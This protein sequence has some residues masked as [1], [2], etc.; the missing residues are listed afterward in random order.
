[1]YYICP[2]VTKNYVGMTDI[3]QVYLEVS[4]VRTCHGVWGVMDSR[5]RVSSV[6]EWTAIVMVA[7][8]IRPVLVYFSS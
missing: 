4:P 7:Y 1:M 3:E 2:S 5:T 8:F 6:D